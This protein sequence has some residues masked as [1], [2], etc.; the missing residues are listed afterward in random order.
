MQR[1]HD[2]NPCQTIADSHPPSEIVPLK[3]GDSFICSRQSFGSSG[4]VLSE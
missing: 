1:R 4:L 2:T 3:N